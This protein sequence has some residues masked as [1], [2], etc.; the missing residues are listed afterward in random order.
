MTL[1]GSIG[2]RVNEMIGTQH[3]L[4][5]TLGFT[6]SEPLELVRSLRLFVD[7]E[8]RWEV[9]DTSL[10]LANVL[11]VALLLLYSRTQ[12]TQKK[13]AGLL[14]AIEE[15]E[16]HLHPQMQRQV[17]RDLLRG[18]RP[19]LV[20]THSPNIAS[21]APIDSLVILRK[22]GNES[23]I[24]TFA[25]APGFT[26]QQLQ[27]LAHYLDVTR[28]EIL[29]GRGII[30]VEGDAEEFMVPAAARILAPPIE[31]DN[32]GISVCSV[33]GTDFIPYA[34]FLNHLGIPYVVITDGDGKDAHTGAATPGFQRA[35]AIL[36]SIAADRMA[37]DG[38]IASGDVPFAFSLLRAAGIFV[39]V[40]TLE[41]DM[42]GAGAGP[43]M[44]AAYQ[45]LRPQTR[46]ATLTPFAHTGV[47]SD[48]DE[49]AA[50]GLIE[51][52]GVGKGRFAQRLAASV[53]ASDVPV[54]VAE[55]IQAIVARCSH[56]KP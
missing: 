54:H 29:F 35:L 49:D 45:D 28:A 8:R 5:P 48:A 32:Y 55:A 2:D 17:F 7:P 34:R 18:K 27:D 6:S 24:R 21:V 46:G 37:I 42:L 44:A 10:G 56:V 30:L 51:R 23:T 36:E 52:P 12:E 39:G 41:A 19:V 14:L 38:A 50:I 20:S 16:A 13:I 11:Y 33:A 26:T 53:V 22:A 40:R 47:M 25:E 15:P 1:A 4:V 31:L 43:R 9:S 3:P